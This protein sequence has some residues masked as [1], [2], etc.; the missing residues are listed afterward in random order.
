MGSLI[1]YRAATE[2]EAA[3]LLA[4]EAKSQAV[5]KLRQARE[6]ADDKLGQACAAFCAYVE[7]EGRDAED[8]ETLGEILYTNPTPSYTGGAE[9]IYTN[10]DAGT[11]SWRD[12]HG[13][14]WATSRTLVAPLRADLVDDV[15]EAL[16]QYEAADAQYKEGLK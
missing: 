15:R 6:E 10:A 16:A 12:P 5:Q 2:A 4:H 9:R 1:T 3:P 7:A 13:A 11:M 14:G 8:G